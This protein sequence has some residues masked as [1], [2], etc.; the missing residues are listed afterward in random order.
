M[1]LRLKCICNPLEDGH[2]A[3]RK[4]WWA[5][6]E[7]QRS[8]VKQKLW[9]PR[10]LL[11]TNERKHEGPRSEWPGALHKPGWR[12]F[13]VLRSSVRG[14]RRAEVTDAPKPPG[15]LWQQHFTWTFMSVLDIRRKCPLL[16]GLLSCLLRHICPEASLHKMCRGKPCSFSF[17]SAHTRSAESIPEA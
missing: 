12:D 9:S 10:F 11:E 8:H 4:P 13:A 7:F 6:L 16:S 14:A 1:K 15:C 17:M 3:A 2:S 5:L